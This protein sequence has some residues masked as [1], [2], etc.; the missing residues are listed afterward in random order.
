VSARAGRLPLASASLFATAV[1]LGVLSAVQPLIALAVVGAGVIAYLTLNDLALGFAILMFLSFLAVLPT[2][3]SLSPAK[4]AGLLLALAWVARFSSTRHGVRDFFADHAL[5]GW[6]ML[7]LLGWAALTLIWAPHTSPALTD[8][9]QY[10]LTLLLIPIAYTAVQSRRDLKI[11]L[12]AIVLGAILAALVGLVQ[13]PD[14]EVVENARATG[15]IGDPNEFAA[16]LLVGLSLG[17]GLAISRGSRTSLRLLGLA[18]IPLC[19][20]GIF[21]SV[22]R[23]GLVAMVIV[24]IVATFAAGRWRLAATLMLM[25]VAAG[26]IVYFTQF[27]PLPARERVLTTNGGTGRTEL[28]HVGLRM[29]KTHPLGGIGAGNYVSVSPEY[30]LEPGLIRHSELIFTKEPKPA[31]NTYLQVSAETGLPGL[32][33]FLIV[34]GGCM[35]CA[36]RAAR[37]AR[38]RNDVTLEGLSRSL[39]L[40]IVGL[41]AAYFFISQIH[42]KILWG[43]LA[44]AP[45]VLAVARHELAE[46]D[47]A[48]ASDGAH[49]PLL[50]AGSS[51]A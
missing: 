13:P 6:A 43:L 26:G 27:A 21:L 4:G 10:F 25:A 8:L 7:A 9:S 17:A 14:A 16:D 22:S 40:A 41:L 33:L 2:A 19:G 24:F 46:E 39:F 28:W 45:A 34:I 48:I 47:L 23:G 3:G 30:T 36:L 38:R 37:I 18:A 5:L 44:L 20:L 15:T 50:Y 11:V 49:A 12:A 1:A 29:V 32:L 51:R 42:S 31:H 35:G